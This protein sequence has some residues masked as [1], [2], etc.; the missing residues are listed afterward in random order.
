MR[1][2]GPLISIG[3]GSSS[4][5]NTTSVRSL[6]PITRAP[7]AMSPGGSTDPGAGCNPVMIGGL[8]GDPAGL[9]AGDGEGDGDGNCSDG[10]AVLV[11]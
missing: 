7:T 5:K 11:L 2:G 9:A 8:L 4:T 1:V 6:E 3:T 10:L